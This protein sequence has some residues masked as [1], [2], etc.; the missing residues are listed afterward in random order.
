MTDEEIMQW[1]DYHESA[2]PSWKRCLKDLKPGSNGEKGPKEFATERLQ[3]LMKNVSLEDAKA[4]TEQILRYEKPPRLEFHALEVSRIAGRMAKDRGDKQDLARFG[5]KTFSCPYCRDSGKVAF[6]VGSAPGLMMADPETGS[7]IRFVDHAWRSW[8]GRQGLRRVVRTDCFCSASRGE[9]RPARAVWD[10]A[11]LAVGRR[12]VP[13]ADGSER[14]GGFGERFWRDLSRAEKASVD[15]CADQLEIEHSPD[16]LRVHRPEEEDPISRKLSKGF[17]VP[18]D[19][20]T[21][22]DGEE[23]ETK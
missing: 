21:D 16:R 5:E 10:K 6:F 22:V 19:I 17:G 14:P 23:G 11:V 3:R 13:L 8:G 4:A 18:F 7:P 9:I 20:R 2:F 15:Q 12:W 1:A